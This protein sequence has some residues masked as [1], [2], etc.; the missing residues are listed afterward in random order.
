MHPPPLPV[1]VASGD[2]T[3]SIGGAGTALG[4]TGSTNSCTVPVLILLVPQVLVVCAQGNHSM[5]RLLG[6][7]NEHAYTCIIYVTHT[8]LHTQQDIY[9]I[10]LYMID[11]DY[12]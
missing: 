10:I 8:K 1:L 9:N 5:G 4:T 12:M 11:Y 2:R 7:R 3:S 6:T